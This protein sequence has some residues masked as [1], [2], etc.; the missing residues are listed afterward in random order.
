M[1]PPG[2]PAV[3][4]NRRDLRLINVLMGNH[5]WLAR[6]LRAGSRPEERLLELGAGTGELAVPLNREGRRV[7]GL[8]RCPAPAGLPPPAR[9]HRA[10]LRHF[11]GYPAY[12]AV[13][14]NLI[15]HQFTAAELRAL[16]ARLQARSRLVVACEPARWRRSQWLFG[17]LAPVF[18]ANYV[19]RHDATVSISAGFI[20]DELPRLLES[21]D[22]EQWLWRC[23]TTPLGAYHMTAWRREVP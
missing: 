10:D 22:P 8:D 20:D 19:S 15:F 5:R 7:D 17:L 11:E 21:L 13:Y 2:H 6:T 12:D 9:W 16:G 18:G 14:G 23:A 3:R 4:H 1:L